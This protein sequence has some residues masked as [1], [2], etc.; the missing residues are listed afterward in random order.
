M[1]NVQARLQQAPEA[2]LPRMFARVRVPRAS[3]Q[4]V[5]TVPETA[6]TYSAYGEQIYIVQP[7]KDRQPSTA[8]RI[9]VR[10]GERR[11]GQVIVEE[12]ISPGD[13]IVV[14]GQIKLSDGAAIETVETSVLDPRKTTAQTGSSQ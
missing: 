14:A 8:H 11:D 1:I 7:G 10:T 2:A 12:G 9:A 3:N 13:R 4:E 5:L 6:V